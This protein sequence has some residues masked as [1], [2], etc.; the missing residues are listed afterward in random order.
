MSAPQSQLEDWIE[1][2]EAVLGAEDDV[3]DDGDGGPDEERAAGQRSRVRWSSWAGFGRTAQY[4]IVGTMRDGVVGLRYALT[5]T[6]RVPVGATVPVGT[7]ARP[8]APWNTLELD[9]AENGR[10]RSCGTGFYLAHTDGCAEWRKVQAEAARWMDLVT[11]LGDHDSVQKAKDAA[12][13]DAV[14]DEAPQGRL[15]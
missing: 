15:F 13:R 6:R 1:D 14:A 3:Q 7:D 12:E 2:A 5:K 8:V 9:Q 11:A 4:A 10:C